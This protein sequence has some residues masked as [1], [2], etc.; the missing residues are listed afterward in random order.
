[1]PST[2]RYMAIVSKMGYTITVGLQM[3]RVRRQN[4]P[5][6]SESPRG[7]RVRDEVTQVVD[8]S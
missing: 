4:P 1:M 6:G 5:D 2:L 3:L 7:T 8:T